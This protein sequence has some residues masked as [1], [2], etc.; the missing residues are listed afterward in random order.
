M[1]IVKDALFS[2][3]VMAFDC[4]RFDKDLKK[5]VV[6]GYFLWLVIGYAFGKL[7]CVERLLILLV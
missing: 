3:Y 1:Y 2:T 5:G 4:L 6:S 7:V